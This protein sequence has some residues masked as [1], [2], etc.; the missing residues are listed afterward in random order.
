MTDDPEDG[1]EPRRNVA[2]RIAAAL[3][4]AACLGLVVYMLL[5]AARP[6]AGLVSFTF[7]LVLPAAA[8]A[9]AAF[10]ADPWFERGAGFYLAIP[11]WTLLGLIAISIVVLREGTICVVILSPLWLISGSIGTIILRETRKRTRRDRTLCTTLLLAP[12]VAMQIEPMIPLPERSYAVTRTIVVAASPDRIWPLLRGIPDVRPGEGKWNFSQ[13]VVGVPR[14][15]GARLL[16]EGAGAERVARWQYGI[17]FRERI[18][19]WR[20]GRR[21]GWSFDFGGSEGWHFTDRHL[22]PDSDYFRVTRG[23]YTL[24]P[25]SGGRTRIT[26][27]THYVI[28]TPVNAYSALWGELFLGDV[29]DNLLAL[30][31][32]RAERPLQAAKASASIE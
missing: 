23:G 4:A 24:E 25:L 26:L 11:F 27:D 28:R 14:P 21:I 9:L 18:T 22:R 12:L 6:S 15:V 8:C 10:V 19:E 7:L 20:P 5:E 30:V 32:Q 29:E 13:D 16:G 31:K 17:G 3:A 1:A 2:P